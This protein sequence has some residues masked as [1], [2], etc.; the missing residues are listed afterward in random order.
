MIARRQGVYWGLRIPAGQSLRG[1]GWVLG[2]GADRPAPAWPGWRAEGPRA[3]VSL[4][5]L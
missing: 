3:L 1:R 5:A 2:F 4:V